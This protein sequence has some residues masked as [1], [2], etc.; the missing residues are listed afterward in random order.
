[1]SYDFLLCTRFFSGIS[2]RGIYS[3]FTFLRKCPRLAGVHNCWPNHSF[4]TSVFRSCRSV[5]LGWDH[6]FWTKSYHCRVTGIS[7]RVVLVYRMGRTYIN[8]GRQTFL[9]VV[10]SQAKPSWNKKL[11]CLQ[12]NSRCFSICEFV[13]YFSTFCYYR[14][15]SYR[16]L[17]FLT[18][19]NIL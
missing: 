16:C 14:M 2:F 11:V 17:H 8:A 1:M 12:L 5:F 13:Y 3:C 19:K 6:S 7:R 10:A 4:I 9:P 15:Y 18:K